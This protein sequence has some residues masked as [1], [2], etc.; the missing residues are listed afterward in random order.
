MAYHDDFHALLTQAFY[1]N[2]DFGHQRAGGI[3]YG[4]ATHFGFLP[5]RLRYAM[6]AE[7]QDAAAR[8][9]GQIFDKHRALLAQVIYYKLVMHHFVTH[10][11][12]RT[13]QGERPLNN[14]NGAINTSTETAWVSQ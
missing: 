4:Q 3:K 13:V 9:I 2:M 5:H 7:Y 6:C 11:D 12:R 10:I 8:H 14:F 1:L